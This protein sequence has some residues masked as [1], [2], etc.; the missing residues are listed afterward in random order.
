VGGI[1][2]LAR[3]PPVAAVIGSVAV[4]MVEAEEET[5]AGEETV[6]AGGAKAAFTPHRNAVQA[7]S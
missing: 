6:A 5:V 3:F 7:F 2:T 4:G 1:A